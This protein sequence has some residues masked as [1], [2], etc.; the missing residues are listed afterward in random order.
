MPT[1][2]ARRA[3]TVVDPAAGARQDAGRSLGGQLCE[4]QEFGDRVALV[5]EK[6]VTDCVGGRV[7]GE[8][9]AVARQSYRWWLLSGSGRGETLA[10]PVGQPGRRR[11]HVL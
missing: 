3:R 11:R 8:H 10:L 1:V 7:F 6:G 4:G 9:G 2:R 5:G